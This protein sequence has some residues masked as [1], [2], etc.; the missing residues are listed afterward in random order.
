MIGLVGVGEG[1]HHQQ[2]HRHRRLHHPTQRQQ[3]GV[4]GRQTEPAE[5]DDAPGQALGLRHVGP[6][7]GQAEVD[8]RVPGCHA[9]VRVR[10][11][12]RRRQVVGLGQERPTQATGDELPGGT[13][14]CGA[15]AHR[16]SSDGGDDG[17]GH[18]QVGLV[19]GRAGGH[20]LLGQLRV[21][22]DVARVVVAVTGQP[23]PHLRPGG[24]Q[25]PVALD[26]LDD[27]LLE[28]LQRVEGVR[29]ARRVHPGRRRRQQD[30]PVARC[31]L[32]RQVL[33]EVG[34]LR[35]VDVAAELGVDPGQPPVARQPDGEVAAG[36]HRLPAAQVALLPEHPQEGGQPVVPV[37]VARQRQHPGLPG[38]RQG[39][40]GQGGPVRAL[41]AV[42][43][44]TGR[45][46]RVHLVAADD[47]QPARG[48][49]HCR[50]RVGD[51][52]LVGRGEQRHRVGRVEPVTEVGD[53]VDPGTP[54]VV[55]RDG[56]RGDRQR[57]LHLAPVGV[58]GEQAR[59]EDLDPDTHHLERR[60]PAHLVLRLEIE[61]SGV[62]AQLYYVHGLRP[63]YSHDEQP[64]TR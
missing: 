14:T 50:R 11:P 33:L 34:D 16:R 41:G 28:P 54:G 12:Q 8:R 49:W 4:A 30:H 17:G 44:G 18:A 58:V 23:E 48:R 39:A 19:R 52:Q 61:G 53:H 21:V 35:E 62:L 45:G 37:V 7:R 38:R 29:V 6:A 63:P 22:L 43:V 59:Q 36:L 27:V 40:C 2:H 3:P 9:R 47:Q 51:V 60:E 57:R 56:E 46:G 10:Q 42:L 25:H 64:T 13:L 26:L 5:P 32:L 1:H 15:R 55:R 20:R 24:L 31:Q